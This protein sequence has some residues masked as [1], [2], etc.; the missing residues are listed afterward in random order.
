MKSPIKYSEEHSTC[1]SHLKKI[2]PKKSV[3]NSFLFFSG[4]LELNLAQADRFV[5]AH[6]DRYVVY[7]FWSCVIN[8]PKTIYDL[9]T[10]ESFENFRNQKIFHIL[11]KNWPRYK[12]PYIRS[13]I[14]FIL[15]RLSTTGLISAGDFD[16][17]GL[18]PI[19][20]SYLKN[21]KVKNFHLR[22][23]K[24][25]EL[26]Q[27]I[28]SHTECDYLLIPAPRFAYN[29]IEGSKMLGLESSKVDHKEVFKTLSALDTKFVLLYRAHP[30]VYELYKD[31]N[32]AMIDRYGSLTN[33]KQNCEDIIVTNF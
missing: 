1:L 31:Y 17:S 7:E 24:D 32:I 14:F 25:L 13:A 33:K 8:D 28:S 20:L 2:I 12:D 22:H 3:I 4:G 23:T 30:A 16:D 6:T 27:A 10:S 5:H 29:L 19:C 15:N 26:T 21:F 11:Q 9:A 18:N